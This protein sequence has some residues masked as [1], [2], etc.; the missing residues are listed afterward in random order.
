MTQ[1]LTGKRFGRW[2]VIERAENRIEG[3]KGK[4]QW[5]CRCDC[6]IERIVTGKRLRSGH[7]QSCGCYRIDCV[8]QAGH[9]RRIRLEGQTFGL[10]TVLQFENGF[11]L[12]SC[13]CGNTCSRKR[14][15][16]IRKHNHSCGCQLEGE[17]IVKNPAYHVWRSM[18]QRCDNPNSK[19]YKHY[20][21][22]GIRLCPQWRS[23][24]QQFLKDVGERP[25]M[26]HTLDRINVNGNYEPGNVRWATREEQA[27]NKRSHQLE[28]D[29]DQLERDRHRLQS[30]L[31]LMVMKSQWPEIETWQYSLFDGIHQQSL[32]DPI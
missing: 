26:D 1:S 31:K 19:N 8:Q 17:G 29:R 7:S 32:F 18:M 23:S 20:G 5:L 2:L 9:Q 21:G 11:W 12:C 22:R 10:L 15:Q 25:T 14:E 3:G 13:H 16:L 6:G 28:R 27:C 30:Q 4:S 24:F